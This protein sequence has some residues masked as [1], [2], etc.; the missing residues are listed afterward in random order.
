[1]ETTETKLLPNSMATGNESSSSLATIEKASE[2]DLF[3]ETTETKLLP[4]SMATGNESS[5]SLATIEKASEEVIAKALQKRYEGLMMVRTKAIKGKGAWYWAHLEP[6]LVRS[7]DSGEPKAVKLRC[8]LCDTIFSAS[9]P[10]RTASEHL[11]RGTCPNFSNPSAATVSAI[12]PQPKPLSSRP[13]ILAC[14]NNSH[15]KRSSAN[16]F[17]IAPITLIDPFRF[18]SPTAT[19]LGGNGDVLFSF[20]DNAPPPP[21]QQHLM[22]SGGKDDFGSLIVAEERVKKL[23]NLKD[24]PSPVLSKE[25]VDY[26]LSLLS[27]WIFESASKVSLSSLEHPKFHAFLHQVGLPPISSRE[28]AGSRLDSRYEEAVTDAEARIRDALF[29]QVAAEGWNSRSGADGDDSVVSL[30]VNLP[31]G[32]TVFR[33]SLVTYSRI[34]PKYAEEVLWDTV[35]DVC[36]GS[37]FRCAGIVSDRF[38]SSALLNLESQNHWMVNLACQVHGFRSLIKD[39]SRSLP[40]FH[41]IA[42]KFSQIATFFQ[43]SLPR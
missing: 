4:N 40:L 11:K 9:N 33:R 35:T 28:I 34:P 29:F 22:L 24:S 6:I 18:H 12:H 31:N 2:E 17:K 36:G 37:P 43:Q 41:N 20:S 14:Q 39:F 16:N 27:D 42:S 19:S 32:S 15:N 30:C 7:P 21:Q 26:A 10:S 5:S 38:K 25:Q 1:M 8:S 23:K 13:R 3:M